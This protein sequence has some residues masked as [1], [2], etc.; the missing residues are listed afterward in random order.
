MIQ[1][2][3]FCRLCDLEKSSWISF[4]GKQ[5]CMKCITEI[6]ESFKNSRTSFIADEVNNDKRN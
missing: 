3:T 6:V 2:K 4:Y 5:V 1:N